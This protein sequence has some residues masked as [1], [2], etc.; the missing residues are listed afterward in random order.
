MKLKTKGLIKLM[1]SELDSGVSLQAIFEKNKSDD[2]KEKKL[3]YLVSSLKDKTLIQKY[4]TAN[5]VLIGIMVVI[6]IIS[7]F[8]GYGIGVEATPNSAI[9]W[10]A[11][12]I[13]PMLFL[14]G[15][16]KINFQAYLAYLFLT[17]S[18]FPKYLI[19]FGAEPVTDIIGLVV[20]ISIIALVWFLKGK[21]FPYMGF[22]GAKKN[23]DKQ[24]LV[25]VNS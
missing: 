12:A 5:N 3:A 16:F 1:Q 10:T 2:I 6:T 4:K 7:A 14:Y 22:L 15:F 11:I 20:S 19:N 9:Y 13:I 23:A 24:Y 8:A 17:I 18:Q 25:A 21:L